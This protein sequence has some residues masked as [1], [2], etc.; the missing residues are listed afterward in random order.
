MCKSQGFGK[1]LETSGSR[2]F[3]LRFLKSIGWYGFSY[4]FLPVLNL[5]HQ[6]FILICT[7]IHSIKCCP[8][9]CTC[10]LCCDIMLVTDLPYS[11]GN[12]GN[13]SYSPPES[14]RQRQKK[15]KLGLKYKYYNV[16]CT[17]VGMHISVATPPPPPEKSIGARPYGFKNLHPSKKPTTVTQQ[18]TKSVDLRQNYVCD[19]HLR[20]KT[21]EIAFNSHVMFITSA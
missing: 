17:F 13:G 5:F 18:L 1:S 16:H 19:C 10:T 3:F 6:C 9:P 8:P 14:T 2:I 11:I 7:N 12:L 20:T 4:G 15:I 21:R